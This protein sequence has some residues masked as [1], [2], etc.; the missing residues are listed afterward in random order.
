MYGHCFP[1]RAVRSS[2]QSIR[3]S[4][5][6]RWTI[7][8]AEAWGTS[9]EE[10][11]DKKESDKKRSAEERLADAIPLGCLGTLSPCKFSHTKPPLLLL[12]AS[13][14]KDIMCNFY[15]LSF[16]EERKVVVFPIPVFSFVVKSRSWRKSQKIRKDADMLV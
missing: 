7:D 4:I 14:N 5:H 8:A 12:G 3:G 9:D 13:K 10:A 1:P 6:V 15:S 2:V 11:S 16:L